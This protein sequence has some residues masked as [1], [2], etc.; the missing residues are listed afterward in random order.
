MEAMQ[1]ILT[2]KSVRTYTG[3]VVTDQQVEQLIEAGMRAPSGL[4]NEPWR[5]AIIRDKAVKSNLARLTKHTKVLEG[6]DVLLCLFMDNEVGYD[7]VKDANTIGACAENVLLAAHAMGLGAVWIA[8]IRKNKDQVTEE[9]GLDP[10]R[11]DMMVVIPVGYSAES[12]D[13]TPRKRTL[14]EVIIARK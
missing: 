10:E 1:A 11:Y 7:V 2:R 13:P 8:E 12:E 14:D 9:C 4:A 5:F 6:A 3:Q